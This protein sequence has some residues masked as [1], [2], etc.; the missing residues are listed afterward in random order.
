M[1]DVG[2][3]GKVKGYDSLYNVIVTFECAGL[4]E[5]RFEM[6]TPRPG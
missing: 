2:E 5:R 6:S 1:T 3:G 4:L